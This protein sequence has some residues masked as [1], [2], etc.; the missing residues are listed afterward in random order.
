M[1]DLKKRPSSYEQVRIKRSDG[2]KTHSGV[3]TNSE[4]IVR[5]KKQTK[6]NY[7]QVISDDNMEISN[8]NV[9]IKIFLADDYMVPL[10]VND[11][12]E[13]SKADEPPGYEQLR[14]KKTRWCN[15]KSNL[16]VNKNSTIVYENYSESRVIK[17]D[18]LKRKRTQVISDQYMKISNNDMPIVIDL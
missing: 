1:T 11:T 3:E 14:T 17:K 8:S 13:Q 7:A 12:S 10:N 6:R 4:S 9:L 18:K 2:Y 5:K 16:G 15:E